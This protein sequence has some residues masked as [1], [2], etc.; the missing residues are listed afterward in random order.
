MKKNVALW[1]LPLAIIIAALVETIVPFVW[2][3][4]LIGETLAY[5]MWQNLYHV[6][7][8]LTNKL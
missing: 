1:L 3:T 8:A 5:D 7:G 4:L 2:Q 6:S